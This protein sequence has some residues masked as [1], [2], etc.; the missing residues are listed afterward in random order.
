M[1]PLTRKYYKRLKKAIRDDQ[2][3]RDK[4]HKGKKKP[5]LTLSQKLLANSIRRVK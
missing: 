1:T 4:Q 5:Q 2:E 3:R